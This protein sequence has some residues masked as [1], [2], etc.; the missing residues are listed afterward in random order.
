MKD[1]GVGTY[2]SFSQSSP[3]TLWP[4][5]TE[6]SSFGSATASTSTS[7]A[8]SSEPVSS[9]KRFD[10]GSS[11]SSTPFGPRD[12]ASSKV[13]DSQKAVSSKAKDKEKEKKDEKKKKAQE[14]KA[15]KDAAK[16]DGAA[17]KKSKK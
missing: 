2:G 10:Y 6:I 4:S 5:R 8:S 1:I 9:M 16:K 13:G 14:A 12:G 3:R 15:K 7:I 11:Y 17:K